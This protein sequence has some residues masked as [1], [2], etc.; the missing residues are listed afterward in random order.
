MTTAGVWLAIFGGHELLAAQRQMCE[1]KT[2]VE[3]FE[4]REMVVGFHGV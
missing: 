2:T 3:T 1:E 4:V